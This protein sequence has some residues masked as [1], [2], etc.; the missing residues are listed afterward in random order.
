MNTFITWL[1]KRGKVEANFMKGID[2]PRLEHHLPKGLSLEQAELLI[3]ACK[4]MRCKYKFEHTRNNAILN[5]LLFTGM[6][7]GEVANLY[8]EDVNINNFTIHIIQ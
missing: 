3:Q 5:L 6:R 1:V 7:K 4:R 8:Y 2:L